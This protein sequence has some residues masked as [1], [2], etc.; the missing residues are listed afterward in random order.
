MSKNSLTVWA[1]IE[2]SKDTIDYTGTPEEIL[3]NVK[4]RILFALTNGEAIG[5]HF[6]RTDLK[7]Q[8]SLDIRPDRELVQH[9]IHLTHKK[10]IPLAEMTSSYIGRHSFQEL[11]DFMGQRVIARILDLITF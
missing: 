2:G 7:L 9:Y 8:A 10:W 5:F 4:T 1:R 11:T 6:T 3:T